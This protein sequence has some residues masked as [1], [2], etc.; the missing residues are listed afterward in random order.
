MYWHVIE[1]RIFHSIA[2]M[3]L[4]LG[5]FCKAMAYI[6]TQH[7]AIEA[8][9]WFTHWSCG[10]VQ[11]LPRLCSSVTHKKNWLERYLIHVRSIKKNFQDTQ[12]L[13]IDWD[14]WKLNLCRIFWLLFWMFEKVLNLVNSFMKHCNSSLVPFEGL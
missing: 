10:L 1:S 14:T 11:T 7:L 4:C 9:L 3:F 13:L 6:I 12:F 5:P 8:K 2:D